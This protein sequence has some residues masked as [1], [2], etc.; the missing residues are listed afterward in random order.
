[1][2]RFINVSSIEV[3]ERQRKEFDAGK[4]QDL[5]SSIEAVGLQQ[6]IV[7]ELVGDRHVLRAGER[8]LR[9]IRDIYDLGGTL[10]Y[11]DSPVP[12]PLIPYVLWTDLTEVQ[13]LQIE[14]DENN[15]REA[16]SWQENAAATAK[17]ARL[18]TLQAESESR[19]APSV[20]QLT[21][22]IKGPEKTGGAFHDS[23]R[24]D[25]ILAR[26]LDDPE[27]A[28]AKTAKEAMTILKRKEQSAKHEA[29][30]R[31]HG[32]AFRH[33]GH[34]IVHADCLEWMPQQPSGQFDIILTDPP[35][36]IGAHDFGEATDSTA[37][38]HEY[39]DSP[40][41]LE[42]IIKT[43][44]AEFYRLTKPEAHL[45]LFCDIDFF[46]QW[47]DGLTAAGW[48]VFRTP[49]IWYKPTGFRTP[50]IKQGP[51]RKYELILYAVKGDRPV[52][53]IVGDVITCATGEGL[54]HS[55]AKPVAL[56]TELL[57]RSAR[58]G[59]RVFDPFA[60]SGPIFPA[61]H[62]LKCLA[63]GVEM[64]E[65]HYGL[66]LGRIAELKEVA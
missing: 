38:A 45:Y 25:L 10:R 47:K 13:R 42:Q 31:E 9:A 48:K 24:Q 65:S 1:M 50:W 18:R 62:A 44:P 56:Y 26:H 58:P 3:Q 15:Q 36:G 32:P 14:V 63:T 11:D 34:Q 16:F 21:A 66:A 7:L 52:N 51:Q 19:P 8:R 28:A 30:A 5:K 43:A 55:A 2:K 60:G 35:Y 41:V 59:D 17:L 6:P 37:R 29:L 40:E 64:V 61:A 33:T 53:M 4:L 20:A 57:R 49:L 27:V 12:S 54:G 23:V 39:E 46:F 22:E